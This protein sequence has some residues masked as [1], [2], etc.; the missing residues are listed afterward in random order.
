MLHQKSPFSLGVGEYKVP[1]WKKA[2]IVMA[3]VAS[4][5]PK[6][7]KKSDPKIVRF[8]TPKSPVFREYENGVRF[9]P[10]RVHK[11]ECLLVQTSFF[12]F[13]FVDFSF[14][15][16]CPFAKKSFFTVLSLQG[17]EFWK[18]PKFENGVFFFVW[19]SVL[20]RCML[21]RNGLQKSRKTKN[22]KSWYRA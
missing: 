2:Q 7:V 1:F 15:F 9:G 10:P 18:M 20:C 17:V 13:F 12:L 3:T 14:L 21:P 5:A 11:P 22:A 19:K 8:G 16:F 4:P 6:K